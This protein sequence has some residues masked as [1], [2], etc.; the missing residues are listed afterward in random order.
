MGPL[1]FFGAPSARTAWMTALVLCLYLQTASTS[2]AQ[3]P[4][5]KLQGAA[6]LPVLPPTPGNPRNTE[7][8]FVTLR[9]GRILFAYTRFSGGVSDHAE[10]IIAGRFSSDGGRTWTSE[11]RTL[12]QQ[13]GK[14]N[15]MSVSLLRLKDGRIA[16]FYLR[17]NSVFDCKPM[18]RFSSDEGRTWSQPVLCIPEPGYW[19]LNND[20]V[21]ELPSGRLVMPVAL[22]APLG[23]DYNPRGVA[24]TYLSDDAGAT[25][26]RGQTVLECPTDSRR[27]FQEPGVVRLTD[28]RLLMFLRTRLGSQ[29]LSTS[30]DDGETWSPAQ[31]SGILSPLSPASIKRIPA[32]GHLLLVWNDH[33]GVPREWRADESLAGKPEGIRTPLTVAISTD[34]G[35]TWQHKQNLMDHPEGWYCY[36]AIHFHEDQVLLGYVSGGVGLPGLSKTDIAVIPVAA[37][38]PR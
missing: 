24:M 38:Y 10:A 15:V 26:R 6:I 5:P 16:L 22:H 37:L 8:A 31:P 20:R 23:A 32:T 14:M 33:A 4:N 25:W 21:V 3:T 34:E 29:Y 9:D 36:T 1:S 2:M 28:G 17:K 11:D 13:E 30:R 12:V 18:V 19:V 35:A 27:G 7:G